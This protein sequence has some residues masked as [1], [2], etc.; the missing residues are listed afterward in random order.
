MTTINELLANFKNLVKKYHYT[1]TEVDTALSGKASKDAATQSVAG[2]MSAADKKKLDEIDTGA[3]AVTIDSTLS[4]SSENPV[5]NKVIKSALDSKAASTHTHNV[6][7]MSDPTAYANIGSA[8]N[9]TQ[10][11][12]NSAI[13]NKLGALLNVELITIESTRPT[14]SASTM[15]KLYLIPE[16]SAETDD[17]YEV[18]VTYKSG[19]NYAWE[20]ID[21]ARL[22][23][24]GYYTKTQTDNTFVKQT[25]FIDTLNTSITN[26]LNA[27]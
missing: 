5:Q 23:L 9:A 7:S 19:N 20:K 10:S 17:A 8:A 18:F 11:T 1:K 22:D 4:D 24:T 15:N 3:T 27:E 21:T 16:D 26:L 6:S 2:L 14:A 12:I 13:D 25:D